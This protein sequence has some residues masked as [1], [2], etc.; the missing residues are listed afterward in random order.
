MT[1]FFVLSALTAQAAEAID[2][3]R[4]VSAATG[5]WDK[6]GSSDL[7]LLVAA[8]PRA[9]TRITRSLYLS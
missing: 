8:R 9:A 5:D 4:I 3:G 6:D 1:A 7:A 2:P